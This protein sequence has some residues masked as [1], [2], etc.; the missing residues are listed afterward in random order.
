MQV[1]VFF[2]VT[3]GSCA[4]VN[5]PFYEK[6]VQSMSTQFSP[7]VLK[8]IK[9]NLKLFFRELNEPPRHK[10]GAD[11]MPNS[12][13]DFIHLIG[14]TNS[15]SAK[16]SGRTAAININSS[17]DYMATDFT[18]HVLPHLNRL[19][20]KIRVLQEN[21]ADI[22]SHAQASISFVQDSLGKTVSDIDGTIVQRATN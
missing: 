10:R 19:L 22:G 21:G 17:L 7:K 14:R 3:F 15:D 11:V 12:V 8:N 20:G 9:L 16:E 6:F 2:L 13:R 5:V 18:T 4:G 1:A